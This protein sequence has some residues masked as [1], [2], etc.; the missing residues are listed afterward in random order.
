M[1]KKEALWRFLL[2]NKKADLEIE[3]LLEWAKVI[4]ILIIILIGILILTGKFSSAIDA[5]ARLFRF[6]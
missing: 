4:V 1:D 2:K 5:I 6:K 3:E